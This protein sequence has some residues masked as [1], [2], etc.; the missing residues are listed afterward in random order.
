MP[1]NDAIASHQMCHTSAKPSTRLNMP[2][3]KPALVFDGMWM[4]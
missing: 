2:T 1:T 4:S 3:N